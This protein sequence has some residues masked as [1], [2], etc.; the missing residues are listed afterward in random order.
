MIDEKPNASDRLMRRS[1]AAK[2]V[3]E[4]YGF[5]CSPKTFAKIACV[6]SD[7]PPFYK[8]G[9]FPLYP[10]SG[11]DAWAKSKLGQLRRSTS[12]RADATTSPQAA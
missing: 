11:L 8:A 12:D 7:G 3:T 9:R 1:E 2:Y 6:S 10:K 4:S 5:P